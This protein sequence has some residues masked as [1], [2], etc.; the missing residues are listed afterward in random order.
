MIVFQRTEEGF[1][2]V[3]TVL[4]GFGGWCFVDKEWVLGSSSIERFLV[5]PLNGAHSRLDGGGV[6]S[7]FNGSHLVDSRVVA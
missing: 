2:L 4:S 1:L 7:M 6:W 3:S 5:S